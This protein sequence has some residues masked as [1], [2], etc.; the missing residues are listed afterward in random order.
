L[1]G[2]YLFIDGAYLEEAY[3]DVMTKVFNDSG[4]I[5]YERLRHALSADRAFY[6]NATETKLASETD[7]QFEARLAVQQ[8]R[9]DA[10]SDL[11]RFHLR[12]GV[13]AGDKKRSRR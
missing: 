4:Q 9:F 10:I 3:R 1:S 11:P 7:P 12:A 13:T 2:V 5:D 8:A 6:Y